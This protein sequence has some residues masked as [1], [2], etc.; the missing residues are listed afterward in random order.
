[1]TVDDAADIP[2]NWPT[3]MRHIM[4]SIFRTMIEDGDI[5]VDDRAAADII[6]DFRSKAAHAGVEDDPESGGYE[7]YPQFDYR[8]T[9]LKK[10]GEEAEC[11]NDLIALM[12]YST[13]F[14]HFVNGMLTHAF[15]RK[16]T[17]EAQAK[18]LLRELRIP[19]KAT[20]LWQLL[21][22]PEISREDLT[23]IEQIAAVRNGFVHY[24]WNAVSE[25]EAT[26]VKESNAALAT[27]ASDV[28]DRL[29][30]LESSTHWGD[31]E[32]ELVRAFNTDLDERGFDRFAMDLLPR[33]KSG[34]PPDRLLT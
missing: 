8:Q 33:L 13:W 30:S 15:T 6:D 25:T 17:P 27:K 18:A 28:V 4:L 23:T 9:L 31:R 2:E 21:E 24:K 11:G 19:T 12:H 5:Q 3:I 7:W 32:D 22:L 29:L 26:R 34:M 1:M 20:A 14:E 10:A 16:R